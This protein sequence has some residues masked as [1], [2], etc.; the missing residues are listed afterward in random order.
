MRIPGIPPGEAGNRNA[1][2]PARRCGERARR[3]HRE[4]GALDALDALSVETPISTPSHLVAGEETARLTVTSYI[5][6]RRKHQKISEVSES[7]VSR[8]V[9]LCESET[10]FIRNLYFSTF[11]LSSRR[12]VDAEVER[13]QS[14]CLNLR[15]MIYIDL[16]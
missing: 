5:D 6:S 14:S 4:R 11:I 13:R 10:I 15:C 3:G 8:K 2:W 9:N 12:L 16:Y 7:E 1:E